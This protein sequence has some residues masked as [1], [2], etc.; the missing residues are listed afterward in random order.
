[1]LELSGSNTPKWS[2]LPESPKTISLDL[3]TTSLDWRNC[4][5]L[6]NGYR[7]D[8][9]GPV[10]YAATEYVDGPLSELLRSERNVLSGHN[11][12]YD[13]LVLASHGYKVNCQLEDTRILAY[14]NWP[15]LEGHGLK[16]L[17]KEKL[18]RAVTSLDEILFKPL[19]REANHLDSFRE[20]YWQ[21]DDKWVR[22]DLLKTYHEDDVMNIDRL[23]AVLGDSDWFR[24]VEMPLTRMLFE[25]ELYGGPLDYKVLS[26]LSDA[27]GEQLDKLGIELERITDEKETFN[28][29]SSDQVKGILVKRGHKLEEICE[30]TKKGAWCVDKALLKK[31]SWKG[32]EFCKVLLEYRRYAKILSTYVEPFLRGA[33]QDG[34]L[35]GS[36]N[37]A[38][39]E[40][41]YGDGAKG[42]NTGRLSSSN[43]NL[44]NIP[45]RTKEGK[46]VR[47]AFIAGK[48]AFM[49][50]SDLSQIEPRLVAHYSQAPKLIHA[51]ANNIDTHGLFANE[52][53]GRSVEKDS[54]ER[55]VGKTSWLATVYGCSYKKLLRICEGYSDT[56]LDL[57]ETQEQKEAFNHLEYKEQLKIQ[58]DC[59]KDYR[60]IHG[61]WMFL[62]NVQDVFT[63][64]NPEIFAWRQAHIDRTRRIGY[65]VTIGGRKI[66]IDGLDSRDW[67]LRFSAERQA[68]NYLIQGSA[69][70]I[71]KMILV[72]FQNEFVKPGLGR[73]FC[74]IHD[75]V[76]GDMW[77]K[78]D[79]AGVK[80][81]MENTVKLRNVQIKSDTKLVN[82]WGEK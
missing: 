7:I 49:F 50:D 68:V 2:S 27:Y 42:T 1:M 54:V 11:I 30:K 33:K 10:V 29:N 32:D 21:I 73:V 15:T 55:F 26:G 53:F 44:Q 19:K 70:D 36:I 35:H 37:Q 41:L 66:A 58:K 4:D 75:E 38:G 39:S 81:I 71:M 67:G 72:R 63:R 25:M 77:N 43:P 56:I 16:F 13:A 24:E 22:K 18:R 48:D 78:S 62:K 12:K 3:E 82:N 52:I 79:I 17:V 60:K 23:R 65:V 20:L 69:A 59:G 9:A 34:K 46:E 76:L 51:Y 5:I 64:K 28:P 74:T 47:K 80:E 45:S 31:L 6:L 57:G 61:Q 14:L 40:D 8:R